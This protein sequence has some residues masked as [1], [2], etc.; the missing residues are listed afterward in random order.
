MRAAPSKEP[1]VRPMGRHGTAG[2]TANIHHTPK[3]MHPRT[4]FSVEAHAI[5]LKWL[6]E[7]NLSE[8]P[9]SLDWMRTEEDVLYDGE[10]F[11]AS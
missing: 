5:P 3:A 2:K 4:T 11:S 8:D 1:A 10:Q 7:R 9:H 6:M